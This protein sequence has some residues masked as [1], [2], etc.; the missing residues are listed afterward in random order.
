VIVLSE[1]LGVRKP[2]PGIY[3]HTLELLQLPAEDCVFV[4]DRAV[5][6]PPAAAL[7]IRTVH[8]TDAAVTVSRLD[9]LLGNVTRRDH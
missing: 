4:D 3:L 7:G 8:H 5:N 9:A 6:L 2:D 1:R